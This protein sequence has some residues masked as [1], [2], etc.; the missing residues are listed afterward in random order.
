MSKKSPLLSKTLWVNLI[1]V[2]AVLIQSQTGVMVDAET[3]M[4]ILAVVNLVLRVATKEPVSWKK[5]ED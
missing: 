4:A 5:T 1:A 2:L 3:Q